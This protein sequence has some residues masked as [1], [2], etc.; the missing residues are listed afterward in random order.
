MET[1]NVTTEAAETGV[2][3]QSG[4]L[5]YEGYIS[6]EDAKEYI[7]TNLMSASRSFIAIGF[8]LKCVRDRKL[9][10]E[11]EHPD[12]WEFAAAEY[13][14]SKST[15]SRY[16]TMNDRFSVGGNSPVIQEEFRL[17]DKSK[18]QE[19]LSLDAEQLEQVRP[20]NTVLEIREMKKPRDIPY[21][22][23]PGQMVLIDDFPEVLPEDYMQEAAIPPAPVQ[24]YSIDAA[25]LFDGM[26]DS[27]AIS[28]QDGIVE[29]V[30]L[31][32]AQIQEKAVVEVI[33]PGVEKSQEKLIEEMV[34]HIC[35]HLC[36]FPR[37]PMEQEQLDEICAGCQMGYYVCGL[38]NKT[39]I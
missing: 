3:T 19:M 34:E 35:D 11:A 24:T 5:W 21:F 8:Y 28:Q 31:G 9:Y 20:E 4:R 2:E 38:L 13:G 26:D 36:R 25:D 10:L 14:L 27:V 18:L 16:M 1:S 33:P 7:R 23:L 29:Y 32:Q 15:A 17:F 12:I 30:A 37:E 6:L 22:D 39:R